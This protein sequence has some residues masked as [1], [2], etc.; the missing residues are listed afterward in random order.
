M[1]LD[2]EGER[3]PII[4]QYSWRRRIIRENARWNITESGDHKIEGSDI[5][6]KEVGRGELVSVV[7]QFCASLRD[8]VTEWW[9]RRCFHRIEV[10]IQFDFLYC[11]WNYVQGNKDQ[12]SISYWICVGFWVPTYWYQRKSWE[13]KGRWRRNMRSDSNQ[14]NKRWPR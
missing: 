11:N 12:N 10:L 5:N 3:P 7:S 4:H 9:G 1:V 2:K 14:S 6:R 13:S 8:M